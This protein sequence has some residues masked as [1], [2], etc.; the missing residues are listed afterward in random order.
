M[1]FYF[2]KLDEKTH[3]KDLAGNA[4]LSVRDIV[5]GMRGWLAKCLMIPSVA[6]DVHIVAVSHRY[7]R[8]NE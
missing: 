6:V 2:F 7:G 1:T 3:V 5:V 8:L 4:V